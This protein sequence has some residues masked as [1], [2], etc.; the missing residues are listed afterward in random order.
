MCLY[1]TA[2]SDPD[3]ETT[4]GPVDD[5]DTRVPRGEVHLSSRVHENSYNLRF[6]LF[7]RYLNE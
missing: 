6:I 4:I 2:S 3:C 7:K 5:F 1:T